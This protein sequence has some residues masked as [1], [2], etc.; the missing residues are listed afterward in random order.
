MSEDAFQFLNEIPKE[1][2]EKFL[3]IFRI[4]QQGHYDSKFLKK[5]N[6]DIWEF[7]TQHKRNQYRLLAF[8]DKTQKSLIVVSHGFLKKENKVPKSEL[9]RALRAMNEYFKK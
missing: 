7:R 4:V 2:S 6:T 9:S 3:R 1:A 8:W 5:L